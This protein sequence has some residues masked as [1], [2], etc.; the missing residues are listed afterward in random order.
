MSGEEAV[1]ENKRILMIRQKRLADVEKRVVP[2]VDK[3]KEEIIILKRK[4]EEAENAVE[5]MQRE[6]RLAKRFFREAE[7]KLQMAME[8][9]AQ[10]LYER[11]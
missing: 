10:L 9:N 8:R 2:T 6:H 11:G 5:R 1:V 3:L 7:F 4:I